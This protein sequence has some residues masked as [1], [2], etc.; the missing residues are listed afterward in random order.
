MVEKLVTIPTNPNVKKPP[1]DMNDSQKRMERNDRLK[2][3][4]RER[5]RAICYTNP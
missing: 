5:K 2:Q 3:A 1:I 4:E